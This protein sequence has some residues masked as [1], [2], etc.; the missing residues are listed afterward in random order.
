MDIVLSIVCKCLQSEV[1]RKHTD[2]SLLQSVVKTP[3]S[4]QNSQCRIFAMMI[5]SN[6]LNHDQETVEN[7]YLK[8]TKE[9]IKSISGLVGEGEDILSF[10]DTVRAIEDNSNTLCTYGGLEL[11]GK[12]IEDSEIVQ[13][14]ERAAVL[15][16][17]LLSK[18][19]QEM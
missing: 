6:Y 5:L 17:A 11:L 8:L 9:D 1:H 13:D 10:L 19:T 4:Q 16:Q 12:V 18:G 2:L 14:I 3:L 7:S 15:L